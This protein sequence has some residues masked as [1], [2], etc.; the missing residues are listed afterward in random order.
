MRDSPIR[1]LGMV[2]MLVAV[3][4]VSAS[5]ATTDEGGRSVDGRR[6]SPFLVQ[7]FAYAVADGVMAPPERCTIAELEQMLNQPNGPSENCPGSFA[8]YPGAEA[9]TSEEQTGVEPQAR[10]GSC[11]YDTRGDYPHRSGGDV[12]AH[13]WWETTTYS[14][15][16]THADVEVWIQGVWCDRWGCR[17]LTAAHDEKRIRPR[18]IYN[19]RTTARRACVSNDVVGFRTVV[20]VDLVGVI[21]PPDRYVG[22]PRDV[23]C[24][25]GPPLSG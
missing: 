11:E 10:A 19:E 25:P 5:A 13:G 18:N 2:L 23:P 4:L 24:R 14:S 6:L 17:W 8:P 9:D 21:D 12:S 7:R 20:D 15:C 1:F 3:P 16:P 22:P